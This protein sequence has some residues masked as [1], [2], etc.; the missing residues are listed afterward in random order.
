MEKEPV[1]AGSGWRVQQGEGWAGD[2]GKEPVLAGEG[3][4]GDTGKE[5]VLAG[6]GWAGEMERCESG[7]FGRSRKPLSSQGDRGFK[8]HPLR[9]T[10]LA[11]PGA[12]RIMRDGI[13]P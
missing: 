10:E 4:A 11:R 12:L 3:W 2:T 6:E 1:L 7:R 9:H 5:P 13:K 8:S